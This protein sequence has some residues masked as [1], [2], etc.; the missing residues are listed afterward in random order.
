MRNVALNFLVG[1][2]LTGIA[3]FSAFSL[4][5]HPLTGIDDANIY[6]V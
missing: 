4:F 2:V 1:L 5:D 3:A 6:F